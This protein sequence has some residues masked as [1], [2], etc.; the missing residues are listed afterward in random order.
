MPDNWQRGFDEAK[1]DIILMSEDKIF[2]ASDCL[3]ICA[4]V[5]SAREAHFITWPIGNSDNSPDKPSFKRKPAFRI[6]KSE[7]IIDTALE[8][9]LD[10]YQKIAPRGINAAV[11]RD[12][13]RALQNRN[14]RLFRPMSPDYS[15]GCFLLSGAE[16]F[17]NTSEILATIPKNSP[18]NGSDVARN[19]EKGKRFFDELGIQRDDTTKD[20]PCKQPLFGNMILADMLGFWRSSQLGDLKNRLNICSYWLMIVAD[21]LLSRKIIAGDPPYVR[22]CLD[23]IQALSYAQRAR[24]FLYALKRYFS[25]WPNRK[26]KMR[27]NMPD[28]IKAACIILMP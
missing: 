28:F 12:F 8:C 20:M 19:T 3:E 15:F 17:L 6:V 25:G 5:F 16:D 22:P 2:L 14:G 27:D 7:S 11:K 9:K 24:I 13:A 4:D 10:V 18:S 1:G 26:L 21:I 23:E